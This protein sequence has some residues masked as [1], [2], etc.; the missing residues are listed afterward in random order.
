MTTIVPEYHTTVKYEN[1][2]YIARPWIISDKDFFLETWADFPTEVVNSNPGRLFERRIN[3]WLKRIE[4][5]NKGYL[6]LDKGYADHVNVI[7]SKNGVS[8]AVHYVDLFWEGDELVSKNYAL[9]VH[10]SFRGQGMQ[11]I[12]SSI[13]QFWTCTDTA[14]VPV[15]RTEYEIYHNNTSSLQIQ[16]DREHHTYVESRPANTFGAPNT[17][18]LIHKFDVSSPGKIIDAIGAT[19]EV[20]LHEYELTNYRYGTKYVTSGEYKNNKQWDEEL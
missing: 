19:F 10:P 7:Y 1:N 8:C 5:P 18:I 13:D 9:A 16:K 2:T 12:I 11:S 14:Q 6:P 3:M 4:R 15:S 17:S 20:A